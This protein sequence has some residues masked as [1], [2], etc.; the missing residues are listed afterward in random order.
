MLPCFSPMYL[1]FQNVL[2]QMDV[3]ICPLHCSHPLRLLWWALV[4]S[5]RACSLDPAD[6]QKNILNT[7]AEQRWFSYGEFGSRWDIQHWKTVTFSFTERWQGQWQ[8]DVF[9]KVIL[10]QTGLSS[11]INIYTWTKKSKCSLSLTLFYSQIKS[12]QQAD[13]LTQTFATMDRT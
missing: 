6:K 10:L 7:N 11:N 1:C 13:I 12:R 3:Q 4:H 2:Y 8:K 9:N 5:Y